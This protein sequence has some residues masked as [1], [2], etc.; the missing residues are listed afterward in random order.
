MSLHKL[1]PIESQDRDGRLPPWEQYIVCTLA[2]M[3]REIG[4]HAVEIGTFHGETTTNIARAMP[5]HFVVTVD[6]PFSATPKFPYNADE[7]K[8]MGAAPMFPDDVKD[9]I[10]C[11]L[12]DSA[13]L[14]LSPEME[15]GFAFIDGAHT[16]EY[17]KNDFTKIEPMVVGGGVVVFHDV[18]MSAGVGKAVEEIMAKYPKWL[19]SAYGGTSLVWGKRK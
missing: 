16:Y 19:W 6:I 18:G 7:R 14:V 13:D 8:Y 15:I 2:M 17:A 9:R 12:T 3:Q 11:V 4:L 1:E 5:H 10:E